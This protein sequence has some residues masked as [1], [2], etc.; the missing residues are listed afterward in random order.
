[1]IRD[2]IT[3]AAARQTQAAQL[4]VAIER[5]GGRLAELAGSLAGPGP[6][7]LGI[8]ASHAAACAP[9]WALRSRGIHAWRLPAGE[10]PLP[11]PVSAHPVVGVSQSGRSAETLATL[12]SVPPQQRL[13]VV[14]QEPSP[15]ATL[16]DRTIGLGGLRD[17]YASTIGFT[18]TVAALG[19]LA[20]VWDGGAIDP[21][22]SALP[23]RFRQVEGELAE[24]VADIGELFT[25]TA[26]VDFVGTGP[27][28][29][30]A[31][32]GALLFREVARIHS[33]AMG[34]RQYL[35]GSMESAGGGVHVLLGD[36]RELTVAR[37]LADAGH[38]V[39][40]VTGKDVPEA[41]LLRTVRLPRLPA[42]QR[43]VLEALFMQALVGAVAEVRGVDVEEFVFHNADTKVGT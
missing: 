9:V 13:A 15:I 27:S 5:I 36:T 23:E 42:A 31:E 14:N 21:G 8:G 20:D 28:V 29:G 26:A 16:V 22:W 18:A 32:A 10:L 37:T 1:V 2:D 30:S 40:L 25:T 12:E 6:I 3:F 11:F 17:S 7:F 41:A 35:H 19:M 34:T 33:T 38:Q 24:R 43:A 39:V 4:A